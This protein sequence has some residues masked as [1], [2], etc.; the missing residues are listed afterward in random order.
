MATIVTSESIE[1]LRQRLS[2]EGRSENTRR[3]YAGDARTFFEWLGSTTL[4]IEEFE[5]KA[6]EHLNYCKD[7]AD[8][9]KST[10]ARRVS[11]LRGFAKYVYGIHNFL[12]NYST[13]KVAGGVPHPL[14]EGLDGVLKMLDTA[15]TAEERAM[16]ALA[17]LCGARISEAR[18]L[19]V[20]DIDVAN[21]TVLLGGKRDKYRH[22]PMS[23]LAMSHI[24]TWMIEVMGMSR[25]DMF[26][27]CDKTARNWMTRIHR[28]A[29][30]SGESASHDLRMTFGTEVYAKTKDIR[31]VQELLGHSSP[32]T[33]EGYIGIRLTAMR[34]AVEFDLTA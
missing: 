18:E 20:S 1:L 8:K 4:P 13:P 33:T 22:V 24:V 34:S 15:S 6:A 3:G 5:A 9:K 7:Y 25:E 21:M 30:L 16:V 19:R 14:E 2:V 23:K 11:G 26:V 32:T 28:E 29:G 31:L 10:T 27:M 17:G 12:P